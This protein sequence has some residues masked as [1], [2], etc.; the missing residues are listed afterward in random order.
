MIEWRG[1]MDDLVHEDTNTR[2]VESAHDVAIVRP[3][4]VIAEYAEAPERRG[5][6]AHA[7]S[8]GIDVPT[9]QEDVIAAE[10]E[11][12]RLR[13]DERGRRGV[14]LGQMRRR[15]GMQIGSEGDSKRP[16]ARWPTLRRDAVPDH[17]DGSLKTERVRDM[18]RPIMPVRLRERPLHYA[19]R[20]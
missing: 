11:G 8:D 3:Q 16:T 7:S 20:S 18:R 6:R 15:T 17:A 19:S 14:E 12:V 10:Q 13:A 2:A 5:H 9:R 4:V 1:Q